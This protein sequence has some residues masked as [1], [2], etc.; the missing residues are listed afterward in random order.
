MHRACIL[1]ARARWNGQRRSL[2]TLRDVAIR[3][4]FEF[5]CAGRAAK[6]VRLALIVNT[7]G[8]PV[9]VHRHPTNGVYGFRSVFVASDRSRLAVMFVRHIKRCN[10]YSRDARPSQQVDFGLMVSAAR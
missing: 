10:Y 2:V 4:R 3:V 5:C 7:P 6:I 9:R 8:G 1:D